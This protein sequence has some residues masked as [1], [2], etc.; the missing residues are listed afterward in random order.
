MLCLWFDRW[1]RVVENRPLLKFYG[2]KNIPVVDADVVAREIV[3]PNTS[4]LQKIVEV[5]R[6]VN[7]L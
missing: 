5:F 3:A 2:L 1:N 6:E 7:S 4:G